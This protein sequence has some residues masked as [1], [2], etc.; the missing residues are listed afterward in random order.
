MAKAL[1][2]VKGGLGNQMFFYAFALYL[3]NLGYK[4][5]LIWF[6]YIYTKHHY[7]VELFDY[8]E[9]SDRRSKRTSDFFVYF[10]YALLFSACKR[11]I[12]KLVRLYYEGRYHICNQSFPY[13]FELISKPQGKTT[14]YFDGWWQNYGYI[15]PIK[16]EL[17]QRFKFKLPTNGHYTQ[18]VPQ[19]R[20]TNSV[21]LHIRRGDYLHKDF[22]DLN[23]ITS[24]DYYIKAIANINQKVTEPVF[25][26]F[27]DDHEWARK[28]FEG[29]DFV[30]VEGNVGR[31]SYIDMY[32]MSMCKHNIISNSTFSWWGAFLNRNPNKI[33]IAPSMWTTNYSATFICPSD[34]TLIQI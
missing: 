22:K 11:M 26:V 17:I 21:A 33:V 18:Y 14:Q 13:A 4:P 20:T 16:K 5:H 2:S 34:W 6:S 12:G 24:L 31:Q 28:N 7:G 8:F 3:K 29:D 27:T 15:E 32:L 25:F 10:G 1:V 19:I 30:F 9:I 23:I